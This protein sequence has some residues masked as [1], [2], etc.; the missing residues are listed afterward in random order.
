MSRMTVGEK[1]YALEH[2]TSP[3][4]ALVDVLHAALLDGLTIN[5]LAMAVQTATARHRRDTF[6]KWL[7]EDPELRAAFQR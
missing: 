1:R 3:F 2:G 5:D 4:C 7:D 6:L